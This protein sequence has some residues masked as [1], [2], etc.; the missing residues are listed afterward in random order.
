MRSSLGVAAQPGKAALAAAT[1]ASVSAW[2]PSEITAQGSSFEGSITSRSW[3]TAGLTQP[4][5]M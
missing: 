4:P 1:A 3:A 5:L 2:P